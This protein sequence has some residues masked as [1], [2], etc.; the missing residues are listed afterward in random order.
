MPQPLPS[1]SYDT[2]IGSNETLERRLKN[3]DDLKKRSSVRRT[4]IYNSKAFKIGKNT[5]PV[6][7]PAAHLSPHPESDVYVNRTRDDEEKPAGMVLF[8]QIGDDVKKVSYAGE[9]SISALSMLF[10]ETFGYSSRQNDFPSIYI[11]EPQAGVAYQLED[12]SEVKDKSVLSL[13]T[14]GKRMVG[15]AGGGEELK[16]HADLYA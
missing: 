8:L 12:L 6:P 4:S 1:V 13:H 10:V 15:K 3:T 9:I 16:Q 11:R 2:N 14:S 7:T 5:P